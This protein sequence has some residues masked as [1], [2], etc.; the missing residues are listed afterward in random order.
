MLED[1][2]NYTAVADKIMI[3][4]LLATDRTMPKAEGLFSHILNSQHIWLSRINKKG[5]L[6]ERFQQQP[7]EQLLSLHLENIK[8]LSKV[9]KERDLNEK[10]RYFNFS[11]V[12]FE[13]RL[14]DVLFHVVNHSS[15]HRGQVV[16][17]LK[18]AGITPPVTDYIILKRQEKL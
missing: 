11:G 10:I 8:E 6:F 1:L 3:D 5:A 13:S 9:L 16:S 2:I 7:R 18:L 12:S 17:L 15:Y 14:S 4:V